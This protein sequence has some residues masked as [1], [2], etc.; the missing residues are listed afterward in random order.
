MTRTASSRTLVHARVTAALHAAGRTGLSYPDLMRAAQGGGA[1]AYSVHALL[2]DLQDE[3]VV[4]LLCGFDG[5]SGYG[6][7][8]AAEAQS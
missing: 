5:P 7:R 3:G 6:Y 4:S 8:L 1:S 2:L